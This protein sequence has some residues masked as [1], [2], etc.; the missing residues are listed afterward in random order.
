MVTWIKSDLTAYKQANRIKID[1]VETV[2]KW[3]IRSL[4]IW[5][6]IFLFD[7]AIG[8]LWFLVH[9]V[10]ILYVDQWLGRIF[11]VHQRRM[12]E[13]AYYLLADLKN[14]G[15]SN[16]DFLEQELISLQERIARELHPYR[17]CEQSEEC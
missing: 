15:N 16:H 6:L 5:L 2:Q 12:I 13:N 7:F 17:E 4:S 9:L 8:P 1:T 11:A 14:Q 10:V 3:A